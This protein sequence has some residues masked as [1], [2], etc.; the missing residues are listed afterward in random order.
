M[1]VL[2]GE[3]LSSVR[4]AF[5]KP[6]IKWSMFDSEVS[7]EP[8]EAGYSVIFQRQKAAWEETRW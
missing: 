5:S 2:T 1:T 4:E 6:S 7:P 3:L 8:L